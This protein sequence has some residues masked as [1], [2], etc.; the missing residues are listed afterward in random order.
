MMTRT[1]CTTRRR[2]KNE[3]EHDDV[4]STYE[5]AAEYRLHELHTENHEKDFTTKDEEE[6]SIPKE[7][8]RSDDRLSD[9]IDIR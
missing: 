7:D 1:K 6:H 3:E 5:I 4:Q 8:R 9:S 2:D